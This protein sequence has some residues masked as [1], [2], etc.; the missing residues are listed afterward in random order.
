[1]ICSSL[2]LNIALVSSDFSLMF[3][4]CAH[5]LQLRLDIDHLGSA[6]TPVTGTCK[7]KYLKGS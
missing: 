3:V 2:P 6:S 4:T 1:M 7:E 5:A